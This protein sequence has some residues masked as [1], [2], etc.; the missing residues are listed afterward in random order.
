M[1]VS[2]DEAVKGIGGDWLGVLEERKSCDYLLAEHLCGF[3]HLFV[4]VGWNI[5]EELPVD[6]SSC[7]ILQPI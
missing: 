6:L 3:F 4:S 2:L 7:I 5:D 1:P